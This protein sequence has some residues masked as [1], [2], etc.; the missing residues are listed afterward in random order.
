MECVCSVLSIR[1][2]DVP[3]V[4]SEEHLTASTHLLSTCTC[5]TAANKAVRV[6][7][8]LSCKSYHLSEKWTT[9]TTGVGGERCDRITYCLMMMI[10][11]LF[12]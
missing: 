12:T 6:V 10:Q 2:P 1:G 9:D 7:S 3:R 11:V 4:H 8:S 5:C